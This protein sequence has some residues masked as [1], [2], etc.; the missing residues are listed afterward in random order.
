MLT[1][2]LYQSKFCYELNLVAIQSLLEGN[3]LSKVEIDGEV[4]DNWVTTIAAECSPSWATLNCTPWRHSKWCA[5]LNSIFTVGCLEN[6]GL[7]N[8]HFAAVQCVRTENC[9]LR[10]LLKKAQCLRVDSKTHIERKLAHVDSEAYLE[11][12]LGYVITRHIQSA[13]IMLDE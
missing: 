2:C 13:E 12:R 7:H 6:S 1:V 10:L 5:T 8:L 3:L 4:G 11:R 9:L